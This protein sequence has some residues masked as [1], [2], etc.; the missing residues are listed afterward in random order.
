MSRVHLLSPI[1]VNVDWLCGDRVGDH[2]KHIATPGDVQKCL[3]RI[4]Q[5][6]VPLRIFFT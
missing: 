5:E 6:L 2:T 1:E 4:P 3:V